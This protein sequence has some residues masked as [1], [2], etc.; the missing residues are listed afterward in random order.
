MVS[1]LN[2]LADVGYRGWSFHPLIWP[3]QIAEVFFVRNLKVSEFF[4]NAT[5]SHLELMWLPSA[6]NSF[7]RFFCIILLCKPEL[8][9]DM[10]LLI[11]RFH[12]CSQSPLAP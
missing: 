10:T 6:Y 1:Y 9:E 7:M 5:F 12:V 11:Y 2:K 4:V 8:I 3:R